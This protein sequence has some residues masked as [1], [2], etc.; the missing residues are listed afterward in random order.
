MRTVD[1]LAGS[2]R[3]LKYR[4]GTPWRARDI[5]AGR[6][7]LVEI[8][9]EEGD[10]PGSAILLVSVSMGPSS[11]DVCR[12]MRIF[13]ALLSLCCRKTVKSPYTAGCGVEAIF[14]FVCRCRLLEQ[15]Q[16][17]ASGIRRSSDCRGVKHNLR[18]AVRIQFCNRI[19]LVRNTSRVLFFVAWRYRYRLLWDVAH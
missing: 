19:S 9:S 16:G 17:T 1:E 8:R 10:G 4:Q 7:R 13:S 2:R 6:L 18:L 3:Y 14:Y 15:V 5:P 12:C 11:T